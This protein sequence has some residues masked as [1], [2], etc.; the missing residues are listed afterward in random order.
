M[1][2]MIASSLV[3]VCSAVASGAAVAQQYGYESYPGNDSGIVRCESVNGRT[4]QCPADT[5][6][7]VRLVRQLSRGACVQGQ[8][9]GYGRNGIWA[10]TGAALPRLAC[11][12]AARRTCRP[13]EGATNS[14]RA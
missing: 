14:S 7:G 13:P 12:R 5:Y 3:L 11:H 4:Q 10:P 6:G 9:W 2:L 1:R 8:N